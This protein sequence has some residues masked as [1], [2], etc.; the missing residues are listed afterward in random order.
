MEL[1][2]YIQSDPCNNRLFDGYIFTRST[3]LNGVGA[4]VTIE[5]STF[6]FKA[7]NMSYTILIVGFPPTKLYLKITINLLFNNKIKIFLTN[8]NKIKI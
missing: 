5:K 8:N 3:K 6:S 7:V 2:T 4:R 1:I